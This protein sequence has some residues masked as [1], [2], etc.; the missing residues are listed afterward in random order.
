MIALVDRYIYSLIARAVVRGVPREWIE[1]V[2]G[3]ALVPD[4]VF[5][6]DINLEQLLPR[7]INATGLNYWEAGQ[8]ILRGRDLYENYRVYQT[9]LLAEYRAMI[10]RFGFQVIDGGQPIGMVFD[11]LKEGVQEI[12]EAMTPG[13]AP[14]PTPAV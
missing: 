10:P 9:D 8:D 3:I 2:Y 7:V 14:T 13:P 12:V 4:R 1:D 11:A 6:L 5:Y